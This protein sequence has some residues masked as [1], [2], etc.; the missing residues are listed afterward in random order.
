MTD[1]SIPSTSAAAQLQ[2]AEQPHEDAQPQATERPQFRTK[3]AQLKQAKREATDRSNL[4]R[5]RL[6][7]QAPVY[8]LTLY[9]SLLLSPHEFAE[10]K[11]RTSK[12]RKALGQIRRW[13]QKYDFQ[14]R[15]FRRAIYLKLRVND[16]NV[17]EDAN[18]SGIIDQS[19][20][21]MQANAALRDEILNGAAMLA[22][23]RREK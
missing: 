22:R 18:F 5:S 4:S 7:D 2:T 19:V 14:D 11:A 20:F 23:K 10:L 16:Q 6:K 21:N 13:M 9:S 1:L 3:A 15:D 12:R 8:N 17:R